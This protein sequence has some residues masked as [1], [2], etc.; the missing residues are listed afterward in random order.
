[1]GPRRGHPPQATLRQALP[2]YAPLTMAQFAFYPGN[3][4]GLP[5]RNFAR[6]FAVV[7]FSRLAEF[8][9]QLPPP[10]PEQWMGKSKSHIE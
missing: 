4:G 2:F 8:V 10:T 5:A 7:A 6:N 3:A 9:R 1:M